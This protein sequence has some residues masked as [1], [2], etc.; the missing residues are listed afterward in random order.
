MSVDPREAWIASSLGRGTTNRLSTDDVA[1]LV[2]VTTWYTAPAGTTLFSRH[3]EP[4]TV[5][6]VRTGL[7]SLRRPT[8]DREPHLSLLGPGDVFGDLA[9]F[10][11]ET[12][13]V[14]A[15]AVEQSELFAIPGDDLLRLVSTRPGIAMRWMESLAIRLTASQDRLQQLLA[16]PLDFQLATLLLHTAGDSGRVEMSQQTLAELLGARRTSVARSL[17]NLE[18]RGLIRKHYRHI[19]LVDRDGLISLTT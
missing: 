17:A 15:K 12:E 1:A 3:E 16:G 18:Q 6:A 8:L 11:H 19:H 5:Y 14:D 13:P 7:V 4:S 9:F 2:E 10:L